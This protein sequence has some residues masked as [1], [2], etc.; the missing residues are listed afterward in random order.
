[1]VN[2][3][4]PVVA[5]SDPERQAFCAVKEERERYVATLTLGVDR[6]ARVATERHRGPPPGPPP[7]GLA[8]GFPGGRPPWI[9]PLKDRLAALI[10]G[11]R[12]S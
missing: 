10:P 7:G 8:G 2:V 1:V 4:D 3:N 11:F 9:Q 5:H 12:R 6:R